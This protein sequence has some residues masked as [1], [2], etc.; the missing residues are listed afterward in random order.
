RRAAQK[1]GSD[2]SGI[3]TAYRSALAGDVIPR[4]WPADRVSVAVIFILKRPHDAGVGVLMRQ[5]P[6]HLG[7]HAQ[8]QF[9][10][11]VVVE[12]VL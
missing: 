12:P 2:C 11:A 5:L 8:H 4:C 7:L 6:P 3:D 10:F 1:A 9:I